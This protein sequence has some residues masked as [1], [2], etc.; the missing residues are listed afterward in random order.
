MVGGVRVESQSNSSPRASNGNVRKRSSN[1]FEA[2][3]KLRET[4]KKNEIDRI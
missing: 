4:S 3:S 1:R 2:T